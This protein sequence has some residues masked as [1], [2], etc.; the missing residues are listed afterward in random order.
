MAGGVRVTTYW[1][2]AKVNLICY[3]A[4]SAAHVEATLLA[5]EAAAAGIGGQGSGALAAD[6][7]TPKSGA[8][9]PGLSARIG[10]DLPY[11]A[12]EHFGGMITAKNPDA[13]GRLLLYIRP[14]N[15]VAAVPSVQHRGKG[16]LNAALEVYPPTMIAGYAARFPG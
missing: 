1:D 9:G 16:Y 10:S 4:P 7:R 3:F 14:G 12:I 11:A 13:Y 6:V 2:H 5:A 8:A 15:I